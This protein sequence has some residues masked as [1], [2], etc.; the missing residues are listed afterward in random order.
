MRQPDWRLRGVESHQ[1][2]G[3]TGGNQG[4]RLVALL[5]GVGTVEEEQPAGQEDDDERSHDEEQDDLEP[6]IAEDDEEVDQ[7]ADKEDQIDEMD[8][9]PG[10]DLIIR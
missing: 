5:D 7:Q 8:Q 3:N 6:G 4:P 9:K 10:P 2:G 1:L